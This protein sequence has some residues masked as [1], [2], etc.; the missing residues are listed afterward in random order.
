MLE[1]GK[2]QRYFAASFW[3]CEAKFLA[4]YAL[5]LVIVASWPQLL[6][7]SSLAFFPTQ[8]KTDENT[9]GKKLSLGSASVASFATNMG[10]HVVPSNPKSTRLYNYAH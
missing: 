2:K 5:G 4:S 1:S 8:R 3:T 9:S 10:L 6:R 7:S